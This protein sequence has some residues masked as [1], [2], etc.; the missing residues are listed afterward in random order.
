MS[1]FVVFEGGDGAGKTTQVGSLVRHLQQRGLDPLVTRQPGGTATGAAIRDI[2]LAAPGGAPIA[3]RAE[4]LLFAADKAQHVDEVIR[5]ALAAGRIVVCDRYTDSSL[6]YQGTGRSLDPES[7]AVLLGWATSGL[8]PDLTVVLDVDPTAAVTRKRGKDRIEDEGIDFHRRVRQH[9]LDL[10][11]Q[12]PE[13]YLVL[14]ARRPIA[15]IAADVAAAV[16]RL[17]SASAR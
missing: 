16:D 2:V 12:A 5:P 10:A 13:R 1:L 6:A 9:F 3:P 17:L 14:D 4:F 15:D 11:E 8:V 7:L